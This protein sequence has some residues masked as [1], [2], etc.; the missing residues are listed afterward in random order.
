MKRA[1]ARSRNSTPGP[2]GIPYEI[3]ALLADLGIDVLSGALS[4][5]A[6]EN[7]EDLLTDACRDEPGLL[8]H[9]FNLALLYC[10]PKKPTG[11]D[12][13]MGD[14]FTPDH[15]RP[16]SVVN[17]DNRLLANACR[18]AWEA[19]LSP[20]VS[21]MQ[22]GFL[23]GRSMLGNVLDIEWEAMRISLRTESGAILLFDFSAAFPS[24]AHEYLITVL[25]ALGAPPSAMNVIKALYS[26]NNCHILTGGCLYEGFAIH[27]GIR[28]GCPLSRLLFAL[29][30]DLLL[31]R[32]AKYCPESMTR[33]FADDTAMATP[34]IYH[35]L[36]IVYGIFSDFA[37]ISGLDL[38]IPKTIMI[39]LAPE[40]EARY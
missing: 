21:A 2:D 38:N 14:Y 12:D 3:W 29:T 9:S 37:K 33:A 24:M 27:A 25:E 1:I 26:C 32:L 4:D 28:Q 16:L 7:F 39:P 31:R 23:R 20:W 18:M 8:Q 35:T 5:L 13:A 36:P 40:A 34:D 15:T 11:H 6:A 30:V 10:I 17:T 22:R 19:M